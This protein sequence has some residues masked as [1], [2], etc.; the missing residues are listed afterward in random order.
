MTSL[1]WPDRLA[2][3]RKLPVRP[4]DNDVERNLET[5]L[6]AGDGLTQ[7]ES[8][9]SSKLLAKTE[10]EVGLDLGET[11]INKSHSPSTDLTP[12]QLCHDLSVVPANYWSLSCW[13]CRN[14]GHSTFSFPRFTMAQRL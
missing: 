2:K 13:T 14:A 1:E 4:E 9:E 3:V 10:K 8:T 11:P 6:F 12:V 5:I 7:S